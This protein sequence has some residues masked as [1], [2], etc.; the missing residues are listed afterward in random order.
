[1]TWIH[2][3]NLAWGVGLRESARPRGHA[4]AEGGLQ[5]WEGCGWSIE[6]EAQLSETKGRGVSRV[7]A[8]RPRGRSP[9]VLCAHPHLPP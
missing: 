8:S 9:T 2:P 6:A 4:E 1:M 3:V 7:Q 5:P